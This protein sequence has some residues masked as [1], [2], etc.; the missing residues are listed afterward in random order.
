MVS[1]LVT[2]MDSAANQLQM[3][4]YGQTGHAFYNPEAGTDPNA[5]LVYSP[6][7]DRLSQQEI[8]RFLASRF[9]NA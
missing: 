9:S 7:A 3:V 5:R 4:L 2:E 8:L 6:E 1:A